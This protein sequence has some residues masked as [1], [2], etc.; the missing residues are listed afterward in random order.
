MSV[1]PNYAGCFILTVAILV[2]TCMKPIVYQKLL[3]ISNKQSA[4]LYINL[5]VLRILL[6]NWKY[7]N[8]VN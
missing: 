4:E 7:S 5:K 1:E 6:S 8:A 2:L 3:G